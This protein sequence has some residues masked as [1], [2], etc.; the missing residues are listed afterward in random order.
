ME[1]PRRYEL[2]DEQWGQN[3]WLFLKYRTGSPSKLDNRLTFNAFFGSLVVMQLGVIYQKNDM[4]LG[5]T[6]PLKE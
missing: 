4:A 5:K 2:S 3:S 6:P 1:Q